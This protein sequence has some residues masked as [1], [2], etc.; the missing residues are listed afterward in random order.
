MNTFQMRFRR[1]VQLVVLGVLLP[2]AKRSWSVFTYNE[3]MWPAY[4]ALWA[5]RMT[6]L[7]LL[8]T[9]VAAIVSRD[10]QPAPIAPA[11]IV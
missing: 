7:L 9:V 3:V 1:I 2:H 5:R 6:G 10:K 8:G 11:K 4:V